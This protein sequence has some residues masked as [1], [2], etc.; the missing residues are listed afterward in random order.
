[1]TKTTE[2][3]MTSSLPPRRATPHPVYWLIAGSLVTI[4]ISQL[5]QR[6]IPDLSGIALAQPTTSAGARG[7]FAFS[8]QLTKNTYG[9][10]V[11]D[12]DTATMWMYE[13]SPQGCLRLAAARSWRYDRY[14]ENHNIC[15]LPPETVEQMVEEQRLNRKQSDESKMP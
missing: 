10:Y 3:N 7:V 4:A 6:G 2:R 15:D 9:V 11:V 14:L 5:T 12:T 8:G 13:N 1:M